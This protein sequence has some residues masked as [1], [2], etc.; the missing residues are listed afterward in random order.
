ME[1]REWILAPNRLPPWLIFLLIDF[2]PIEKRKKRK[3]R[4]NS[5]IWRPMQMKL[6]KTSSSWFFILFRGKPRGLCNFPVRKV[7]RFSGIS[8][9]FVLL[10]Q[11][12]FFIS[13]RFSSNVFLFFPCF[14]FFVGVFLLPLR[15]SFFLRFPA[16][17]KCGPGWLHN[18]PQPTRVE[19][20]P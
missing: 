11:G 18:S 6:Y 1:D 19:K 16:A 14:F 4:R 2:C 9:C 20:S 7:R 3:W 17:N 13:F 5:Q 12:F 8:S 10:F 15:W